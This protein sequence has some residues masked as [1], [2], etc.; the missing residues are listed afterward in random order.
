MP[1]DRGAAYLAAC[2]IYRDDA[3]YLAEWI[4]FHRLAGVERFILYDNGSTDHHMDVLTPYVDEGIATV[5]DWPQP[6]LGHRGRPVA[7]VTAFEHCVSAHRDDAR[8]IAFLDV[9]EFLFAPGGTT[10]PEVL[11][12][13]EDHPGVVVN[14]AEFGPSGHVGRPEGL[15]IENYVQRRPLRPDDE[16]PYKSIVDPARVLRCITPHGFAYRDGPAVDERGRPV[17]VRNNIFRTPVSWERLRVHHYWS[18]SEE[19][20][21]L[22]SE[23]WRDAAAPRASADPGAAEPGRRGGDMEVEM[24]LRHARWNR[25]PEQIRSVTD[26]SLAAHGP[27]VREALARRTKVS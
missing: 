6:F 27:A 25:P 18:R 19:E 2:T 10:L 11:R 4:E 16:V 20:H 1:A 7:I 21:R 23:L 8:W 26:E 9:D 3:D 15:V 13:Y 14:R 5:H 17:E 22:K 12:E 24:R